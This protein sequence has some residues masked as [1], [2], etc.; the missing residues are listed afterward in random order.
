MFNSA[1]AC[2]A[3]ISSGSPVQTVV[4]PLNVALATLA[5]LALVTTSL[6]I[7]HTVA[8]EESVISPLSPSVRVGILKSPLHRRVLPFTVLMFV[9][10]TRIA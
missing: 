5:I 3:V 8:L 1:V 10:D 7:V 9:P 4:R 2:V 6:S